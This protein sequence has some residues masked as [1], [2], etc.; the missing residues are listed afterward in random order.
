MI[1]I[2]FASAGILKSFKLSTNVRQAKLIYSFFSEI[3]DNI[4]FLGA[5]TN[6]I[7]NSL[8]KK[9]EYKE[10]G[11]NFNM[12]FNEGKDICHTAFERIG[13][14]DTVGQIEHLN[15]ILK[16]IDTL[17]I[18]SQKELEE[19]SKLYLTLGLCTGVMATII[20]I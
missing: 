4:R 6:E 14:T 9:G 17:I 7:V 1:A 12:V 11:N 19:K 13:K 18:K 8:L 16:K 15:A 2:P 5:E 20:I 10:L 3:K